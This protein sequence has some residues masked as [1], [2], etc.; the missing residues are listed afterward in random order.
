MRFCILMALCA[1]IV[2]A[3][4]MSI[5]EYE[6]VSTLVVP[7]TKVARAK[8]PFIDVHNHQRRLRS[9]ADVEKLIA[10]MDRINMRAMVN[11]SGGSGERLQRSVA[12][13]GP[14]NGKRVVVFANIDLKGVDEPGYGERIARQFADDVR[15]GARGL[16][17]YKSFGMTVRDRQDKRLL[18]VAGVSFVLCLLFLML[19]Y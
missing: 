19:S 3:Q 15:N 9:P 7:E 5:E 13:L 16:K 11:L 10:D 12:I 1:C 2:S 14:H 17:L 4:E 8:F 18:M 6:P